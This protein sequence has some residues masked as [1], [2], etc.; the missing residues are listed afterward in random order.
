[1]RGSRGRA[2]ALA[3]RRAAVRGPAAATAL[4]VLPLVRGGGGYTG[5]RTDR[6]ALQE[7][8][9][10]AGSPDGDTLPDLETLRAR[11]RDLVRNE[12]I[13]GGAVNTNVTSVVGV[14]LTPRPAL[15][16]ELLGLADEAADAWERQAD[17]V[18][19]S[20]AGTTACD[21]RRKNTFAG[22]TALVL[23]S[24]LE[25]G[26]ILALRRYKERKGD[27]LGLRVQLVEADRLSNPRHLPDTDRLAGGV[28]RDED[29]APVRYHVLNRH[30]GDVFTPVAQEW[31]ALPAFGAI[32]GEPLV[33]HVFQ[34][35]RAEQSRGV[36]YL[37]PVIEALRQ[38]GRYT[39]AELMA[40]V[41][42]SFFTVFVK[43]SGD[44]TGGLGVPGAAGGA[45]ADVDGAR[46]SSQLKMGHGAILDLGPDESIET[47]NPGR[48]NDKFDPFVQAILRQVGVRLEIPF[49][50]LI[51]HFTASYS[52]SRAAML[53][54]W[55]AFLARRAWLVRD[56]AQ[57]CYEWA[58][59]EAIARG[60][61][62]APGF[63]DNPLIRRAWLNAEWTGPAQ[64][65]IDPLKEVK[66]ARERVAEGFSTRQEETAQLT[67]GDWETKHAQLAKETRLRREA[68]LDIEPVAERI[69]SSST[70][71]VVEDADKTE[72]S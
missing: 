38:L 40:A 35:E 72:E 65:Q 71:E 50:L 30:P 28:E 11:S 2:R 9:P 1:M 54:A 12:P 14:G 63:F 34:Q 48:P 55:R 56:W 6:R 33:L 39:D 46:S 53:E 42:S 43:S 51:K 19:K 60:L 17:R 45:D 61:L 58:I 67:G 4:S 37:A 36:P 44:D 27:L 31:I 16:R 3:A 26:D 5:A 69:V 22:L 62:P 70:T 15:D 24:A 29:G 7:W 18:W 21:L 25:S 20:W 59:A 23:R 32:S 49:E 64:G 8:T 47:A 52:A 41:I 68:G 13:A 66:A 57:P 10:F